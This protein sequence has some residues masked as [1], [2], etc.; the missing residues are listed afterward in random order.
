MYI[1]TTAIADELSFYKSEL[2]QSELLSNS[3]ISCVASFDAL[4]SL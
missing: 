1:H 4:L 3:S 2:E